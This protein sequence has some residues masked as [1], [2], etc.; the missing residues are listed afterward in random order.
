MNKKQGFC[1]ILIVTHWILWFIYMYSVSYIHIWT[2]GMDYFIKAHYFLLEEYKLWHAFSFLGMAVWPVALQVGLKNSH[3]RM[4]DSQFSLMAA[5][6]NKN[7]VNCSDIVRIR[8]LFCLYTTCSTGG[9]RYLLAP[10]PF[11]TSWVFTFNTLHLGR[12]ISC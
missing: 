8:I 1:V 5:V 10:V 4:D 6:I 2:I 9:S 3:V 7:E 11:S 12:P